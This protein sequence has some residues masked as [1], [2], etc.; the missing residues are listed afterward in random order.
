M[1]VTADELYGRY[2]SGDAAAGDQLMLRLADQ[3][4]AYLNAFL[5]NRQDAEDMMLDC[6]T[7]ILVNKPAIEAGH[8]RAYLFK[9]ARNKANRLWKLR[10]RR[11]EFNLDEALLSGGASPEA[12]ALAGETRAA[13]ERCLN[14]IA[15]Q[16]RETLYLAYDMGMSYAQAAQVLGCS[17]K[18]VE[19]RLYN[20]KK[21]L[22]QEL[23]KEGI[24][25]ADI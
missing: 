7:V 19:D 21:R 17:V 24:T 22:R 1:A 12:A 5:H 8:F 10:F 16:Y 2:L 18:A 14:R 20:G 25:D 13:L 3:L 9:I 11:R 6:F 4:T 23:A 15:P